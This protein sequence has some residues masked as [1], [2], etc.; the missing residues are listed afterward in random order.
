MDSGIYGLVDPRNGKLY[1]VGAT[2]NFSKRY[3]GHLEGS[4][5]ELKK[6]VAEL[7]Q[8]NLKPKMVIFEET[9]T[10][11]AKRECWWMAWAIRNKQPIVNHANRPLEH[12][13]R[14]ERSAARRKE[15]EGNDP[16]PC[17][18]CGCLCGWSN[19]RGCKFPKGE[20]FEKIRAVRYWIN[21]DCVAEKMVEV[22]KCCVCGKYVGIRYKDGAF[23][24][25]R[26]VRCRIC[27]RWY[28]QRCEEC[29]HKDYIGEDVC[30]K[31]DL[32]NAKTA[33]R[34]GYTGHMI[35]VVSVI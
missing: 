4:S 8:E 1:Y 12:T 3:Y 22:T 16:D 29:T 34:L 23:I 27:G 14:K 17:P 30:T 25:R 33:E 2:K 32:F 5:A 9:D 15:R 11:L 26:A 20:E 13:W 31:V 7:R 35:F 28:C 10:D 6:I 19:R 18:E 21:L 24:Q